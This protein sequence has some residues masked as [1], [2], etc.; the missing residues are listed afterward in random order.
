[1]RSSAVVAAE[2]K[3]GTPGAALPPY[4]Q[5]TTDA[6]EYGMSVFPTFV[7]EM[8]ARTRIYDVLVR[9]CRGIDRGDHAYCREAYHD[10]ATDD[11]GAGVEPVDKFLATSAKRHASLQHNMHTVGNVVVDFMSPDVAAVESYCIAVEW[12]HE[13]YDFSLRSISDP[14][15]AGA[16]ILS[17]CRFGDVFERREGVWKIFER[18]LI[19]GDMSYEP[20]ATEPVMPP[21]FRLQ[22]HGSDDPIFPIIARAQERAAEVAS[23]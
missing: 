9:Y 1:L 22:R 23:L 14:G 17:F 13:G 10:G 19:F 20:L 7:E 11:H 5:N 3:P 12:Y 21:G 4:P 16:R 15:L 8:E 2:T 6:E 18:I